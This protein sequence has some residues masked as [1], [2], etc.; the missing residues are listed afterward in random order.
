RHVPDNPDQLSL[1]EAFTADEGQ[2]PEPEKQTITYQRGVT[3]RPIG[4][5]HDRSNGATFSCDFTPPKGV[6]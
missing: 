2:Q 1:G 3:D 6:D 5:T 4:A